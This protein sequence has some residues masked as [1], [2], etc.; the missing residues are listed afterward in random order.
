LNT[1]ASNELV[2][3]PNN[4][5]A[6]YYDTSEKIES[7][8]PGYLKSASKSKKHMYSMGKS[9]GLKKKNMRSFTFFVTD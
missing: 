3:W 6:L 5:T 1:C 2:F 9:R 7:L 8:S 4:S